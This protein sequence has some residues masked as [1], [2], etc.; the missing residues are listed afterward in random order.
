MDHFSSVGTWGGNKLMELPT[1]VF[2][3]NKQLGFL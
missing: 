2:D 1:G 3:Y